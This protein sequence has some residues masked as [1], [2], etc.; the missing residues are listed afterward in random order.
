MVGLVTS[1][2][3][4]SAPTDET[5]SGALRLFLA[6]MDRGALEPSARR[7]AYQLLSTPARRRLRERSELATALAGRDFHPWDMLAEGRYRL[8]FAPKSA[9]GMRE[10]VSGER[11]VVIVTGAREGQVAEVPM[12]QERGRWR[13]DLTIPPV[14]EEE[15]TVGP[16]MAPGPPAR[17][18]Q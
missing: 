11:A 18:I 4:S 14:R 13:V 16:P 8:R 15:E 3:C 12:R 9:G 17:E 1:V 2:A 10:R 5:P 7:E 6:A